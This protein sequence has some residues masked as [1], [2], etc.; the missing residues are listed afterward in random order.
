MAYVIR[1]TRYIH[2][3]Q[4]PPRYLLKEVI[5]G[6]EGDYQTIQYSTRKAAQAA[7]DA[8]ESEPYFTSGDEYACRDYKVLRT[9][10]LPAYLAGDI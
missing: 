10:Q 4:T 5:W 2:N 1:V 7:V 6:S 9:N 3:P 8:L